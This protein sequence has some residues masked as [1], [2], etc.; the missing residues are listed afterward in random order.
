MAK[1]QS[2]IRLNDEGVIGHL[3]YYHDVL[4]EELDNKRIEEAKRILG[5]L[6]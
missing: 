3:D 2:V 4:K 1:V 6:N 5:D